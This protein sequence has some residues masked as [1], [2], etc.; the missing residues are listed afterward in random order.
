M[1]Q[2]EKAQ[3]LQKKKKRERERKERR[4]ARKLREMTGFVEMST[5]PLWHR[6]VLA[7]GTIHGGGSSQACEGQRLSFRCSWS[8]T[9]PGP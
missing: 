9:V 7:G 3:A 5:V 2:L 8:V 6:S 1:L 4:K